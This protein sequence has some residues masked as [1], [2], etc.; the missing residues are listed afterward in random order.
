MKQFTGSYWASD[1]PSDVE[2]PGH[3]PLMVSCGIGV[4]SVAMLV[5]MK[6]RGI[7]PDLILFADTGS[8][9][10]QTYLYV[11]VLRQ[12]LRDVAF[13]DLV[14]VKYFGP[15]AQDH[16]LAD[17]CRRKAMLPDIAYAF[18]R[19]GCSVKWKHDPMEAW[20]KRW[21]GDRTEADLAIGFDATETKRTFRAE[22]KGQTW[23]TSYPLQDWGWNRERAEAE[24]DAEGL[25]VPVKS[26]CYMCPSMK[27]WEIQQLRENDPEA[28]AAAIEIEEG[29][30]A[31]K[32]Y[33]GPD[34]TVQGLG[35][36]FQ[37]GELDV[38][39][40]PAAVPECQ[41]TLF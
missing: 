38:I 19:R 30:R 8:E 20:R 1:L 6:N 34:A 11:P 12:W 39:Q 22:L 29:F 13:P 4:D 17:S 2:L 5:G 18:G 16:S 7:R 26:A 35:C 10:A 36:S 41:L 14:T 24:I 23:N 37:W 40:E 3:A 33:R 15:R 21:L 32:N 27:K 28:Y 31:G 25:P 9:K